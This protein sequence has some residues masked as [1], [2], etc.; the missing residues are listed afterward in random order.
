MSNRKIEL[1]RL[2]ELVGAVCDEDAS[3]EELAELDSLATADRDS[4]RRYLAYC[5][6][7]NMLGLEL[8][9]NHATQAVYQQIGIQPGLSGSSELD[10]MN[11][12]PPTSR[13]PANLFHGAFGYVGSGWPMAYLT[14]TVI[15]GIGLLIG[16]LVHVSKP[17][18]IANPLPTVLRSNPTP[19]SRVELVGRITGIVDCTGAGVAEDSTSVMLGR[20]I[21][22]T[23]GLMEI[24]YN[25][26]AK[27][28]LHGP[29]TY[30][31]GSKNGGFLS[32]GKLTGR[33]EAEAAKGFTVHT[34]TATV[35]DL[36]TEFDVEVDKQG[37]TTSH[38]LRGTV[39]FQATARGGNA[40]CMDRILHQ[41]EAATV[42]A[43]GEVESANSSPSSD[44]V[45]AMPRF[46]T[47]ILSTKDGCGADTFIRDGEFAD[48]NCGKEGA[49]AAKNSA[50]GVSRKAYLRFD[51]SS[52][53][54]LKIVDARFELAMAIRWRTPCVLQVYG[55][56]DAVS[57]DALPTQG[58][59][60]ESSPSKGQSGAAGITW[61]TAPANQPDSGNAFTSDAVLLGEFELTPNMQP[62]PNHHVQR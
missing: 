54:K 50:K 32:A 35:T 20:K 37:R 16:A 10:G 15:V 29:V 17:M 47:I 36:G 41:N 23:S 51:L 5:R 12:P 8:C 61:A 59:W 13:A 39:R 43:S 46:R 1:D 56:R 48:K 26:G 58:G 7:H 30:E 42:G 38:V 11:V 21:E 40:K 14:A 2:F 60:L 6:M 53:A 24:T 27:V 34:P 22:L 62:G 57:G 18:Q 45:Y 28:I 4:C 3:Q 25:T 55:L 52:L 19:E 44:L 33:V 9:A 31:I 49:L